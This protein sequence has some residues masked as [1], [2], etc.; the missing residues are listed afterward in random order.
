VRRANSEQIYVRQL[1]LSFPARISVSGVGSIVAGMERLLVPKAAGRYSGGIQRAAGLSVPPDDATA[2]KRRHS[3]NW[4][5]AALLH[6]FLLSS[7]THTV[8]PDAKRNCL[9]ASGRAA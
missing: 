3:W 4:S 1:C 2:G 7:P 8:Q 9:V 5:A 6:S